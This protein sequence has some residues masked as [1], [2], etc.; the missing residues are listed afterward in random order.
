MS[1]ALR[2][3]DAVAVGF[4]HSKNLS[5]GMEYVEENGIT[6]WREIEGWTPPEP[7]DEIELDVI[8]NDWQ[9]PGRDELLVADPYADLPAE[10]RRLH[11]RQHELTTLAETVS[12][13][14]RAQAELASIPVKIAAFHKQDDEARAERERLGAELGEARERILTETWIP[15]AERFCEANDQLRAIDITAQRQGVRPTG[16][17]RP[18]VRAQHDHDFRLLL[19]RLRG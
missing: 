19:A 9:E 14:K 16:S 8:Q 11:E 5:E 4:D 13:S 3:R 10:S 12:L 18:E 2:E 6:S 7:E 15:A 17:E 1:T